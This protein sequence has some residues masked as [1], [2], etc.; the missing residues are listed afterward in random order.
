M[1]M[2][3]P[4]RNAFLRNQKGVGLIET[5][6]AAVVLLI[7]VMAVMTLFVVAVAQNKAQGDYGTHVTT[8]AQDKMEQLRSLPNFDDPGLCGAMAANLTC[9]SVD[10]ANP[11]AGYVDYLSPTGVVGGGAA[12][13][14]F[15]RQWQINTEATGRIKTI[16]VRTTAPAVANQTAPVTILTTFK[17]KDGF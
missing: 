9:G 1:A 11:Q 6:I 4:R 14:T 3:N 8:I 7:G 12:Q 17:S 2:D 16:T 13:A 15:T 5:M 10:P